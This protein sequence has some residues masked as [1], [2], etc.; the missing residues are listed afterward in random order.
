MIEVCHKV[1]SY[2]TRDGCGQVGSNIVICNNSGGSSVIV[3][4]LQALSLEGRAILEK[5][6]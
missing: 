5:I 2:G 3:G 6:N 4:R 1:G